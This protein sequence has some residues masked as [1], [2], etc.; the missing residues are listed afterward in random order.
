MA[1]SDPMLYWALI[2]IVL[3][4][5]ELIL[6]GGIVVF[7]GAACLL[8]AG[9]I[10]V[11]LVEGWAQSL[12]LWFISSIVLLLSFRQLTQRLVGGDSHVGNTDEELDLFNLPARVK[13]TI[14]PGEKTGRIEFQGA[15]WPALGDGSEIPVGTRVKV[16]CRDNIALVVE[17][18]DDSE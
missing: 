15:D 11:G 18:L 13:E 4:L 7:L 1:S 17:P 9:A 5:A 12:T 10:W 6:P 16:I 2:G 8:V 14:G 3:M